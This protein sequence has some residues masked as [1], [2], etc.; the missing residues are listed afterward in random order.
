MLFGHYITAGNGSRN[1]SYLQTPVRIFRQILDDGELA[2]A[3]DST[4]KTLL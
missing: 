2:V 1:V 4:L 3:S